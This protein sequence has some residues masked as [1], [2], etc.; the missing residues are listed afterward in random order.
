MK[1]K[2]AVLPKGQNELHIQYGVNTQ[3]TVF[4]PKPFMKTWIRIQR[5]G[6]RKSKDNDCIHVY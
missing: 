1:L 6:V 3:E 4:C 5:S 2:A